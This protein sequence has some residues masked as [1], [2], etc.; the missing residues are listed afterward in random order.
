MRL[1]AALALSAALG[2]TDK[3]SE[4]SKLRGMLD[5]EYEV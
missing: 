4:F 5:G 2:D 1:L 3:N